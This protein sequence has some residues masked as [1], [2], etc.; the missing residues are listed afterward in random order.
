M[1]ERKKDGKK[2][3]IRELFVLPT[4]KKGRQV[5]SICLDRTKISHQTTF[6]ILLWRQGPLENL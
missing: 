4:F 1:K 5:F 3:R 6:S 2:E